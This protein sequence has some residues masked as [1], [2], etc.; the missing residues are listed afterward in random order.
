VKGSSALKVGLL[1]LL[2]LAGTYWAIKEIKK[3][4][5]GPQGIKLWALFKDSTG[6]VPKSRVQIAGINVGSI[7]NE[8][9]PKEYPNKAKITIQVTRPETAIWDNAIIFKKSASL[10]GE[11]YLEI[12]PGGPVSIDKGVRH[13]HHQLKD[14]DQILYVVE[15][16]SFGDIQT[17][18]AETLPILQDILR[19]VKEL[20]SGP[21]KEIA[22][23]VNRSI[24]ENSEA[25]KKLLD[26]AD[27]AA[28]DIGTITSREKNDMIRTLQNVRDIT[29]GVRNLVGSQ[30]PTNEKTRETLEKVSSAA[31]KLDHA[32]SQL[33]QIVTN[34]NAGHGTVGRL[35]KDEA[36]AENVQQITEDAGGFI[37]SLTRLQ[38]IIGLRSEFNVLANTFKT[39]VAVQLQPRSDKYYLIE[40]IDDP[41]GV[42]HE[43]IQVVNT[44]DPTRPQTFSQQT[45]TVTDQFRFSF[46]FAKRALPYTWLRF[47][48]KESTGGIGAD[49]DLHLITL[50]LTLSLDLYDFR[51]NTYPR[52]KVLAALEMFRTLYLVGGVDDMLNGRAQVG[53]GG[54]RDYFVGA[55]L[56][57]NDEDLRGL[58]LFGGGLIAGATASK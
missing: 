17:Q 45:I 39:Y 36:I 31:D 46:Q 48:I 55:Q 7:I 27:R 15:P 30:S 24:L 13:E 19:D 47:G 29:E 42:R 57:F 34:T 54:G 11:F 14:G 37:R 4:G 2:V 43:Q 18:I 22:E 21:V 25:L 56:R 32:L 6:L 49:F 8:E 50:P 28:S 10:L 16:T 9:L 5:L 52:L 1:V 53:S 58:L 23:N 40:L 20:T 33:D 41:R 3:G 12:N 44:T 35:L 51:S 26:D 38:T